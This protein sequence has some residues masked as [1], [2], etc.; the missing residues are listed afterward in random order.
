MATRVTDGARG[1]FFSGC[2]PRFARLTASPL[3]RAC[4][5][6]TKSDMKKKR[7]CSQSTRKRERSSGGKDQGC[8]LLKFYC[9]DIK[10]QN[11]TWWENNP[12]KSISKSAEQTNWFASNHSPYFLK[13]PKRKG[14]NLIWF[15]NRNFQSFYVFFLLLAWFFPQS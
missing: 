4:I 9:I 2:S 11:L 7:D 13:P 3:P 14:A 6:L 15:S 10:P 8:L 12:L 5:A 1:F